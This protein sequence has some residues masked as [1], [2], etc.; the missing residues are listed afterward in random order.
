MSRPKTLGY[1]V[2]D[3]MRDGL[4]EADDGVLYIATSFYGATLF[5]SRRE[6]QKALDRTK[7]NAKEWSFRAEFHFQR[8]EIVRVA[9]R[10][11]QK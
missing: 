7:A 6:A 1:I 2:V 5:P 11:R 9:E 3:D 8:W 4:S 10:E